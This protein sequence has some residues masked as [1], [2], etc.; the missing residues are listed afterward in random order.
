VFD[1][2]NAQ[3]ALYLIMEYVRGLDLAHIVN[4]DGPIPWTRC[5][6]LLAQICSAL[7]TSRLPSVEARWLAS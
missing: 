4:R 3:G 6:P 7:A 5:A 1:F 2:G